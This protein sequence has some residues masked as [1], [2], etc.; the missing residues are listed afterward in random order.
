MKY[1]YQKKPYNILLKKISKLF[2]IKVGIEVEC[3]QQTRCVEKK[4]K[5][6]WLC[7]FGC[8]QISIHTWVN[9]RQNEPNPCIHGC[10]MCTVFKMLNT[11]FPNLSKQWAK[12]KWA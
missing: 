5:K 8:K 9:S 11:S 7:E 4:M 10:A 6:N 1:V 3:Q 2:N 12:P